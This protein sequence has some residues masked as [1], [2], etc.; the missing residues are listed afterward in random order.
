MCVL[1]CWVT[2]KWCMNPINLIMYGMYKKWI[3]WRWFYSDWHEKH[4]KNK[5][6][7][8]GEKN[9]EKGKPF[10][11]H[12]HGTLCLRIISIHFY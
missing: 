12:L 4:K 7:G 9:M 8:E 5:T 11:S 2:R 3:F 6:K 10:V 1:V